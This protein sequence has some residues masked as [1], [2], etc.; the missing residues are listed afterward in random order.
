MCRGFLRTPKAQRGRQ[1][2]ACAGTS[3][4]CRSRAVP[5]VGLQH[6]RRG[7]KGGAVKVTGENKS[8]EEAVIYT[9]V[10]LLTTLFRHLYLYFLLLCLSQVFARLRWRH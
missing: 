6:S 2:G 3:A 8:D 5:R 9:A 1:P 10:Q 7:F 4:C